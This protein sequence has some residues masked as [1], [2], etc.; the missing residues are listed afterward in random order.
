M[1]TLT[2]LP[3]EV[4]ELI[5]EQLD[6]KALCSCVQVSRL[7][8]AIFLPF[9][10]QRIRV[11]AS[12]KHPP[13]QGFAALAAHA[14]LVTDLEIVGP[15]PEEYYTI[16][17]P[18]LK[19]LKIEASRSSDPQDRTLLH[20]AL[21]RANPTVQDLTLHTISFKATNEFWEV[22]ETEWIRPR[23]LNI[24]FHIVEPPQSIAFW[25][26]CSRF[27][28]LSIYNDDIP[29]FPRG[30]EEGVAFSQQQQPPVDVFPDIERLA[31][32]FY[33]TGYGGAP[34]HVDWIRRCPRLVHLAWDLIGCWSTI[35]RLVVELK[36]TTWPGLSS[37]RIEHSKHTDKNFSDLV[38]S[39]PHLR[40]LELVQSTFGP[41]SFAALKAHP[42]MRNLHTFSVLNCQGFTGDMAQAV[43][44]QCP[45][46]DT[47]AA[48]YI[49]VHNVA[50]EDSQPWVCAPS[51]RFF[52]IYVTCGPRSTIESCQKMFDQ[53]GLLSNIIHLDLG[54]HRLVYLPIKI[55]TQFITH[56]SALSLSLSSHNGGLA[57]FVGLT[58]LR[59]FS[60]QLTPQSLGMK[61][62]QWM[63]DHWAHLGTIVG[64]FTNTDIPFSRLFDLFQQNGIAYSEIK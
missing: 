45:T 31:L 33:P 57:N 21:I 63:L 14:S 9:L 53:L 64:Q 44:E 47:F 59:H 5:V 28:T 24:D 46:L 34:D 43:L 6:R 48:P 13:S 52:S 55:R 26:A 27:E 61:E 18:H 11:S 56:E 19:T 39:L 50:H 49:S 41:L 58:R 25:R 2:S 62:V 16:S 1:T 38:T 17:F 10:W 12:P 60:F 23:S 7:F 29:F 54:A 51:L 35:E 40:I 4:K 32:R 30:L 3:I 37:L 42:Q 8:R 15:L 22:I 36:N 20:V